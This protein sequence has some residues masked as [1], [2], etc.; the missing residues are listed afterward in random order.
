MIIYTDGKCGGLS[1][2]MNPA[3]T[4]ND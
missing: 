3:F 1:H 2:G 4:R